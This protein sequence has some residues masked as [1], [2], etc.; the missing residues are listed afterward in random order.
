MSVLRKDFEDVQRGDDR[1]KEFKQR[2]K[3]VEY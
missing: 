2:M 3:I 1:W